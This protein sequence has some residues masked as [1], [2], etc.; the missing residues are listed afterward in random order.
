MAAGPDRRFYRY[1]KEFSQ[2][3]NSSEINIKD[4]SL[5]VKEM[6]TNNFLFDNYILE[7]K[8]NTEN[9]VE[10]N[11]GIVFL[12]KGNFGG[13]KT[14]YGNTVQK[15]KNIEFVN[16]VVAPPNTLQFIIQDKNY[17][18]NEQIMNIFINNFKNASKYVIMSL[19]IG[20]IL[21]N[22]IL[23]NNILNTTDLHYDI[24]ENQNQL[25]T[26][27]VYDQNVRTLLIENY[28]E[29]GYSDL[30]KYL[31]NLNK[32]NYNFKTR[33]K[34]ICKIMLEMSKCLKF[35]NDNKI[36]YGDTKAENFCINRTNDFT[37]KNL[38]ILKIKI[39]DFG[40]SMPYNYFGINFKNNIRYAI[41][42]NFRFKYDLKYTPRFSL[43]CRDI[44]KLIKENNINVADLNDN[45]S[46]MTQN[47]D[48]YIFN[49]KMDI[50]MLGKCFYFLLD[51][52]T[53]ELKKYQ[54][55]NSKITNPSPLYDIYFRKRN[56][57]NKG[58]TYYDILI[59]YPEFGVLKDNKDVYIADV[60]N[61]IDKLL[62][63]RGI[64]ND[65]KNELN[66]YKTDFQQRKNYEPTDN[67][68]KYLLDQ[69]VKFSEKMG[70]DEPKKRPTFEVI[71]S[72]FEMKY[73]KSKNL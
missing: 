8:D 68:D 45:Q 24:T 46:N 13:Y 35:L 16:L 47:K 26:N 33:Y 25:K 70:H 10:S 21:N 9:Y 1:F 14:I 12:N 4:Q 27:D 28:V 55:D 11:N 71:V 54:I 30:S 40:T 73:N 39:L 52:D 34:I 49:E 32:Q 22:Y 63:K 37:D 62:G 56:N 5:I 72:F 17:F 58:L 65:K 29:Q 38:D 48:K 60:N 50:Y 36:F 53:D 57:F 19:G 66:K 69:L 51:I 31:Q 6:G 59:K 20:P 18:K 41:F 3:V 61:L 42:R 15:L 7:K 67:K 64:T 23:N 2:F 44:R 43:G